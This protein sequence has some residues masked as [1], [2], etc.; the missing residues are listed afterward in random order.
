MATFADCQ[1]IAQRVLHQRTDRGIGRGVG[2]NRGIL[3]RINEFRVR[4]LGIDGI[5]PLLNVGLGR[6]AS[7]PLEGGA[8][9]VERIIF[10]ESRIESRGLRG[11]GSRLAQDLV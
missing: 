10:G 1:R 4:D 11:F 5:D 2:Q 8:D 6:R 9:R 7:S 3:L